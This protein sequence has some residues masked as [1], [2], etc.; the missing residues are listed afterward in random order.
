M[1]TVNLSDAQDQYENKQP[2][3]SPKETF[4]LEIKTK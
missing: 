2:F 1:K 4:E 3:E